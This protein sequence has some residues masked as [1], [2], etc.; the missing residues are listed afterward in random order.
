MD[1]SIPMEL[2]ISPISFIGKFSSLVEQFPPSMHLIILPFPIIVAAI[3]VKKFAFSISMPIFLQA[4]IT[5]SSF[6]LFDDKLDLRAIFTLRFFWFIRGLFID[7]HN[8]W[9]VLIFVAIRLLR[10]GLGLEG[11][12]WS[13]I[14]LIFLWN[15]SLNPLFIVSFFKQGWN[16]WLFCLKLLLVFLLIIL[17]FRLLFLNLFLVVDRV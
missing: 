11:R 12:G 10:C 7:F 2:I 5:T 4:F 13:G 15:R 8:C 3:L 17:L 6:I 16:Y 1:L 9:V 14:L